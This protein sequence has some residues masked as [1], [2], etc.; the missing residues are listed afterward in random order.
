M[1]VEST[2]RPDRRVPPSWMI[3]G[4]LGLAVALTMAAVISAN[5]GG[6]TNPDALSYL[7]AT[8]LG[9]L[10]LVRRRYPVLVLAITVLGLF[11]YYAAGYPAVG[12]AVPIAA[13]LYSAAELGRVAW[14]IGAGILALATSVF[15]RLA[16]GQEVS[17]VIGYEFAGHAFLMA[18]AVALGDSNRSRRA[19]VARAREVVALTSERARRESD[20]K[21]QAQHLAIARD[22]H[23]SI[24]HSTSVVSLHADVAREA[25]ARDDSVSA[26]EAL[27]LIKDTTAST[28]L[29]LR[30]TVAVLRTPDLPARDP[31]SLS[32]VRGL[33][34]LV[35]G[36]EISTDIHI[37]VDL[38]GDVDIAAFRI[39]QESLTNIVKHS[40]ATK[41]HIRT[42]H[43]GDWFWVSITDNGGRKKSGV[44]TA[45]TTGHGLEG[46]LERA[47]AVGG[48]VEAG[49]V[50]DGFAIHAKLPLDG[51]S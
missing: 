51:R 22:L 50:R 12:V 29:E 28:M 10:M 16:E 23:D 7:W 45:A 25:I 35:S 47:T 13:A 49:S 20:A 48:T 44:S 6:R 40:S 8:G 1:K 15:F 5:H 18:G 46:M 2:I 30:R 19:L 11:A 38:P 33:I 14:A 24:G 4:L 31:A 42:S 34:G 17:L 39:I 21:T 37:P 43:R 32:D 36:V 41:A 27:Q 26:T 3:D 9:A